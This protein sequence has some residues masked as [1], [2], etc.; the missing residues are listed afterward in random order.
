MCRQ[1]L[2]GSGRDLGSNR[3]CL[4][5]QSPGQCPVVCVPSPGQEKIAGKSLEPGESPSCW[6]WQV[7]TQCGCTCLCTAQALSPICQNTSGWPRPAAILRWHWGLWALGCSRVCNCK[8]QDQAVDP[9]AEQGC[10]PPHPRAG[11][12]TQRGLREGPASSSSLGS[13]ARVT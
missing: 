1:V 6:R 5:C 2:S 11:Q 4:T 9:A 10:S 8:S 7:S 13:S 3:Y 12:D